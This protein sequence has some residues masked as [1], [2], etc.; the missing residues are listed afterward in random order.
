MFDLYSYLSGK[1]A[2]PSHG[3]SGPQML[4]N[5]PW[6]DA[7]RLYVSLED[8]TKAVEGA[9]VVYPAGSYNCFKCGKKSRQFVYLYAELEGVSYTQARTDLALQRAGK[10]GRA[11]PPPPRRHPPLA[12]LEPTEGIHP[13]GFKPCWDEDARK[14]R[15]PSYL[16]M[17]GVTRET[18]RAYGLG[19]C[20]DG[21]YA[22]RAV[23]PI[24]CPMGS[25]YQTRSMDPECEKKFRF[26]S[27][28][29]AGRLLFGWTL[30]E[31]AETLCVNEGPH[32][33]LSVYQAALTLAPGVGAV[34]ILGKRLRAE[35]IRM[36]RRHKAKRIVLMLDGD[37]LDDALEQHKQLGARVE[38]CGLLDPDLPADDEAQLDAGDCAQMGEPERIIEAL[39]RC[40]PPEEVR[41]ERIREKV[42]RLQARFAR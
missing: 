2:K 33:V 32:D 28:P 31:N 1:R 29:G 30:A 5:C 12:T 9:D 38:V 18:A 22:H 42:Q 4:L 19:W 21:K 16:K 10:L 24:V 8:H 14:Y 25:S 39:K 6:C 13:E 23:Y 20:E 17:R 37:A 26:L 40:R 34:G 27:G 11:L 7:L 36:I 35:Q 15:I 41:V 3:S